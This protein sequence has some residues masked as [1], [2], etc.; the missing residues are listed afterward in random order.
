MMHGLVKSFL[1]AFAGLVPALASVGQAG[2]QPLSDGY[3][4]ASRSRMQ[5]MPEITQAV[6]P[7]PMAVRAIPQQRAQRTALPHLSSRFGYRMHPILG[8]RALHAG[9]DIPGPM[10]SPVQ[11]SAGGVVS[12]AG[13][14]GGYGAMVEIDHGNG[15]RTRYAH[16]SRLGVRGG[17]LV[18]T[19]DTIGL[20]GASGRA[21][22]SHLH[23]EVRV[24]GRA[25]DPLDWLGQAF[26]RAA[27]RAREFAAVGGAW[28]PSEPHLSDY[29][30][31]RHEQGSSMGKGL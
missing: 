18:N 26:P 29:A 4:A 12:F 28:V 30:R 11:A 3:D 7:M 13:R 21:T 1:A 9:I 19:G 31:A 16:L 27:L 8:R 25:T 10:G 17:M 6:M 15:L 22:G 23:F 14:S 20:M 2:A 5:A 24:H